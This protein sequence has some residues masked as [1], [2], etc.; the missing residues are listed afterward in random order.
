MTPRLK[1]PATR[2]VR[3]RV[4]DSAA[5]DDFPMR[6]DDIVISTYPKCG[7]TWMQR[8][9]GMLVFADETPFPLRAISPWPDF[10][11]NPLNATKE[12]AARQTH[13]RFF[14]SHLPYEALPVY[15]GVKFIHVARDGRDASMSFFNH[16]A[17]YTPKV[18]E[19]FVQVSLDDL[20]FGDTFEAVPKNPA[21]H[22][23]DWLDGPEDDLGDPRASFFAIEN[24]FWSARN[25]INAC[26]ADFL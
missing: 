14:K 10:R 6:A 7:T 17:N 23:G 5:W 13:R 2:S 4:F 8:I 11:L 25:E 3:S 9:V 12:M 21:D 20:K 15:E 1:R 26:K 18:V 19:G 24:S 16:K 22:F